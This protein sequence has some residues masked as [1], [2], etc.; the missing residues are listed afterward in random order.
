MWTALL[1][2]GMTSDTCAL[3]A[4]AEVTAHWNRGGGIQ[5]M[6][7][8]ET[9]LDVMPSDVT[10]PLCDPCHDEL[11]EAVEGARGGENRMAEWEG[12]HQLGA[13]AA[14]IDVERVR[15]AST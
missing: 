8:A 1:C 12:K 11:A 3:C 10:I 9:D 6:L 13:V 4:D 5:R 14:R 7:A 15:D 2:S